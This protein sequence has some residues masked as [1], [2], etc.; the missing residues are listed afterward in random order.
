MQIKGKGDM[1][2]YFLI[3]NEKRE[4]PFEPPPTGTEAAPPPAG[5]LANNKPPSSG[6]LIPGESTF[7][8]SYLIQ[9]PSQ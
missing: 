3:G 1:H 9:G 2:T 7:L 6:K 8:L 5:K 4:I